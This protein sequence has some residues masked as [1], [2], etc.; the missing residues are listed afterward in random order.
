M[1]D[2]KESEVISRMKNS[3]LEA[4]D[5]SKQLAVSWRKGPQYDRL[6]KHL[7]RIEDDCRII[8]AFRMDERWLNIGMTMGAAHK[9]AGGWLRGYTMPGE[10]GKRI[11]VRWSAGALNGM[12]VMLGMNLGQLYESV[13]KLATARTGTM[14]PIVTPLPTERTVT[15]VNGYDSTEGGILLPRAS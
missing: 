11:K 12:F 5:A 15:R 9:Y 14:N 7:L 8:A 3:I 6:R 2:I 13:E 4:M 10:N 1:S